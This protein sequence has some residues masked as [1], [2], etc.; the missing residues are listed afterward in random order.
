MPEE[1]KSTIREN[2]REY[3]ARF[4]SLEVAA[5][6]LKN[7]GATTLRNA[8]NP[9]FPNI[10]DAM[11]R[12]LRAQIGGGGLKTEWS[13][14]N[15]T[16]V[17]DLRFVM[18]DTQQEQGFTWA[19]SPAGSG[20]TVA[21][22]MYAREEKNVF[23]LQC[24]ADMSKSEFAIDLARAVGLRVNSQR[25]ARLLIIE[26]CEYLAELENPLLILDEGDKLRESL[27]AYFITIYNRLHEVAGILFLSTSYIEKRMEVGLRLNKPGYQELWSRLGRKFYVVD[28]N[29]TNDVQHIAFENGV[30][31]D[32]DLQAVRVDAVNADLDLRRVQK[33]VVAIRKKNNN[34]A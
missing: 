26:V 5:N 2:L 13:Y 25:K 8:L 27:I 1:A 15:T 6:T 33:K 17:E 18:R 9:E 29:N 31:G 14:V 21:A 11:W 10:S 7:V 24:D 32:R 16:A 30:T 28:R 34:N 23:H 22:T 3:C 19:V 12:S 4:P 20:K